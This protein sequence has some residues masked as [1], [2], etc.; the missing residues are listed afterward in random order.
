MKFSESPELRS[1]ELQT[2]NVRLAAVF[3]YNRVPINIVD[4]RPAR[5]MIYFRTSK[6]NKAIRLADD[7][8]SCKIKVDL[9]D[10]IT[11]YETV[12]QWLR[13]VRNNEG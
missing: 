11:A 13:D 3:H 1:R 2:G 5:K 9:C 12:R 8:Y 7:F 6:T 10:F 4:L